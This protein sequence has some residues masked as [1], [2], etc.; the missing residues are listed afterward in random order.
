VKDPRWQPRDAAI[1]RTLTGLSWPSFEFGVNWRANAGPAAA[2]MS[3]AEAM[4]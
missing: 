1:V 4:R 2:Q 3:P